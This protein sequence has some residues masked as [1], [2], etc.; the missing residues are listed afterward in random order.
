MQKRVCGPHTHRHCANRTAALSKPGEPHLQRERVSAASFQRDYFLV[1]P[2]GVGHQPRAREALCRVITWRGTVHSASQLSSHFGRA[3][4]ASSA[5]V[6][7]VANT[8]SPVDRLKQS[9]SIRQYPAGHP[10]SVLSRLSAAAAEEPTATPI[11]TSTVR[12][13]VRIFYSAHEVLNARI[14]TGQALCYLIGNCMPI[15][16]RRDWSIGTPITREC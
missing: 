2:W 9:V 12:K 10:D 3:V 14:N 13:F 16:I 1:A 4:S 5:R 8:T 15:G 11:T 6:G 7:G